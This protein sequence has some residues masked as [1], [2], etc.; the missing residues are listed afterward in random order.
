MAGYSGTPLVKKLGIKTGHR[1]CIIGAPRGYLTKTLGRLP[2]GVTKVALDTGSLDLI[3]FFTKQHN[4]LAVRLPALRDA[5]V[6]DGCVWI[7]WP[8]RSSG[9]AT[10]LDGNA[11]R[12]L[13]LRSGMVDVKVCAV[14]A[15][16]SGLKFM[17]RVKDRQP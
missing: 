3:Q 9:V 12:D 6:S 2:S 16:W 17:I 11:V 7:S 4:D 8:K 1:V 5:I 10:D 14:D 15:T 13:G